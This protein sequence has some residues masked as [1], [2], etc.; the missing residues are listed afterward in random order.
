MR[1][2]R[3]YAKMSDIS[4]VCIQISQLTSFLA[5]KI[6]EYF[7]LNEASKVNLNADKRMLKMSAIFDKVYQDFFQYALV[8]E[9]L[10]NIDCLYICFV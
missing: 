9:I 2:Y 6:K 7:T 4:L 5:S 1:K 10:F 3:P 8:F